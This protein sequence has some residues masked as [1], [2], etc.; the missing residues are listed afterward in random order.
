MNHFKPAILI[1][2]V[3][4]FNQGLLA[5]SKAIN[6][7]KYNIN[8]TPTQEKISIDGLLNEDIWKNAEKS[9]KLQRVTPTDTGFAIAQTSVMIARDESNLYVSAI[10][11]DPTP[12][13]RPVLSLR[14]DFTWWGNDQFDLFFDTY[15]DY[16]N[17]Y[18]FYVSAA[19]VQ[20]DGLIYDGNKMNWT[21]DAK[22]ESAIKS[23][24]DSWVVEIK[25]PLRSIRYFEGDE[26]WGINFGRMDWKTNEKSAWAPMPRQFFHN[27]LAYTGSLKWDKPLKKSGLR[28]SLIPYI[29]GKVTRDNITA[30][31]T[32]WGG[33]AGF[34]TKVMLSS[35][36]NL[37]L[38]VN[39]DYSQVEEDR[40]Q[41]NLDRFELFFPERRQFF[42]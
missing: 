18:A 37:D 17:G 33:E 12:G 11:L 8:I 41:T 6:R 26:T 14:R 19:G 20:A 1:L 10:C 31:K 13:K 35:S 40:Q 25:L 9:G 2:I 4:M 27:D 32:V 42:F 34:D 30:Q 36:M 22:W 7:D 21:W 28:F 3:L 38:T 15:N 16:T 5:Q 39:P 29:K 24:D 23:Y